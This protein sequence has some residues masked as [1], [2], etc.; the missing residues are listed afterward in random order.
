VIVTLLSASGIPEGTGG[1]RAGVVV[2][3]EGRGAVGGRGDGGVGVGGV[4]G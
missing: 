4:G 2:V 3:V 1:V